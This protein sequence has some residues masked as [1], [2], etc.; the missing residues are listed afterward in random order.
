MNGGQVEIRRSSE[1][2]A[3]TFNGY[4]FLIGLPILWFLSYLLI[5]SA[6]PGLDS[7]KAGKVTF[8]FVLVGT[9]LVNLIFVT[10][11]FMVQPNQTRVITLFGK[12]A[13][14]ERT[15][16]LRWI[17]PWMAKKKVSVRAH[18]IHSERVKINDLRGNPVDIACNVVWRVRDTAQAVFDVDDY[19]EFVNIQIE[20]GLRTVGARHPYDD[21]S[22]DDQ[23]TLRGSADVINSELQAE[24]NDRLAVAGIVVDEA[25]L[26]HLAYAQEIAGAMLRRQQAEA[27]IAARSKIVMGAV[28]MVEDALDK[29]GKD[30]IVELDDE[31]R[32]AMV[33]NLMV[34]LC[35][36][37][38]AQPV[39]NAGTLYQ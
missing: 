37:R 14:T 16:G 17:W 21:M 23:T 31:R 15:D 8:A 25:G 3:Q 24:L 4:F 28:S 7:G 36:D 18:N 19:R 13:G 5:S 22:E 39:V 38:E 9:V 12:Y 32:A 33:S 2:P 26:T 34:V 20:A 35:G 27:I 29:L 30:G 10:G 11:F 1:R 6:L